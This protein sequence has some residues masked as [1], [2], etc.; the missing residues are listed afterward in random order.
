MYKTLVIIFFISTSGLVAQTNTKEFNNKLAKADALFDND[1]FDG[2]LYWYLDI[3]KYDSLNPKINFSIGVCYLNSRTE[4]IKAIRYLEKA[5]E[6]TDMNNNIKEC[7][8]KED[9]A[10]LNAFKFLGDAYHLAYKFDLAIESYTKYKILVTNRKDKAMID[11]VSRKIE[12]CDVGKELVASPV[13][14]KIENMGKNINSAYPDYCPVLSADEAM[15]VFTTRR[16]ESTGGKVDDF[17]LFFEDIYITRKTDSVWSKAVSIGPP[18][19]TDGNEATVG[20]SVDGQIIL[21]YKD[22]KGDGN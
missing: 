3:V 20:I 2:A 9:K 17:G 16:P 13:K 14:V 12:M 21:I 5:I 8:E 1:K 11:E 7:T 18:I 19:N 10:H 4:K 15:M 22:D 6:C